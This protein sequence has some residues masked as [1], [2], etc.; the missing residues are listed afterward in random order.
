MVKTFEIITV[1]ISFV[2]LDAEFGVIEGQLM[3][4][5]LQIGL[6]SDRI[7]FRQL[8]ST[9]VH[10]ITRSGL[11]VVVVDTGHSVVVGL[12][13]TELGLDGVGQLGD[14]LDH[15]AVR[16]FF[17]GRTYAS[18]T[19]ESFVGPEAERRRR[20]GRRRRGQTYRRIHWLIRIELIELNQCL[21]VTRIIV[22]VFIAVKTQNSSP[23]ALN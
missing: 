21:F 9:W 3:E 5:Q 10:V 16:Q 8:F 4:T 1:G 20:R 7:Q 12:V 23:F 13:K 17:V 22:Y 6:G 11:L 2:E 15:I 19:F 18:D 14:H